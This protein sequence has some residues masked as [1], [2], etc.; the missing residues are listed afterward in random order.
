MHYAIPKCPYHI[1]STA[2]SPFFYEIV[3]LPTNVVKCYGCSQNFVDKYRIPPY[4]IVLKHKYRRIRDIIPTASQCLSQ[5]FKTRTIISTLHRYNVKTP[6]LIISE[7]KW[8]RDIIII[9]THGNNKQIWTYYFCLD[10]KP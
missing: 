7:H 5:I 8:Q 3:F 6:N 9:W 1:W 4:N 10:W 2:S